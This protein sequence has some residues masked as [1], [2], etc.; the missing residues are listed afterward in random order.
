MA[1]AAPERLTSPS[2]QCP[3]LGRWY[4]VV[5]LAA[6]LMGAPALRGTFLG[7]DDIQLV[8]NHVL[9]NQPSFAHFVK[10]FAIAHRD[11][12]QPVAMV[13]FQ[14]DFVVVN[15][16]G[17]AP[18]E[19]GGVPHA[20]V[21]HAT[22]VLLHGLCA[23]LVC[24]LAARVTRS[25]TLALVAGLIFA[26]HPLNVETVAW[27]NGRMTLLSTLFLLAALLLLERYRRDGGWWRGAVAVALVALCHMS[28]VRPELPLLLAVPVL[29]AWQRPARGW[30]L[31]WG[32]V[33]LATAFF[34]VLNLQ[35]SQGMLEEGA[36][37]LHGPR[38]VR[39]VLALGW[40][41]TRIFVPLGLSPYH[42][43]P[44]AVTWHQPGLLVAALAVV[45]ALVAV[46][47]SIRW[48]RL[49]WAGALWML[50]ALGATLPLV[51]SR[52]LA[53]A[54][55]YMY[56]PLAG[57]VW[58]LAALL[59]VVARRVPRTLACTVGLVLAVAFA[60]VSWHTI[61]YYRDNVTRAA[62]MA[63]LYPGYPKVRLAYAQALLGANQL[64]R[65]DALARELTS[66]SDSSVAS[67]AWQAL[68]QIADERGDPDEALR[69]FQAAVQAAPDTA[70]A[71][72]HLGKALLA[73]NRVEEAARELA[74]AADLA[75]NYNPALLDLAQAYWQL[76]RTDDARR[77][78]TQVLG[79]NP[80]DTAALV[81]LA[82][83]DIAGGDYAAALDRLATAGRI[84]P[85]DPQVRAL[86]A[87]ARYMAGDWPGAAGQVREALALAPDQPLGRIVSVGLALAQGAPAQALAI[88]SELTK[89]RVLDDAALFDAFA[90]V[91][92]MLAQRDT[93]NPWPYY[94]MAMACH[95]TGRDEAAHMAA[96]AF[97][98]MN[99]DPQWH[100]RIDA[101]LAEGREK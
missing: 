67:E 66:A 11:L 98:Q 101:L 55:R 79:N 19:A 43:T 6:V 51:A 24:A 28:K 46:A 62:R 30:W 92:Q 60:A 90:G 56:L 34:V 54:D 42:P 12:Y 82:Q 75:P 21:F 18:Q 84:T 31:A 16:L 39:T 77:V 94:V 74:R 63:E 89:E 52:N 10:L 71:H 17:G 81:G 27:I 70:L 64:D 26:L 44:P 4:A 83:L 29:V 100:Q 76:G 25:G 57:V 72:A 87:W 88:T 20:W 86:D 78:Y 93:E 73:A 65:A 58:P 59:L 2:P 8:R 49:G 37:F 96:D 97:K 35:F 33:A 15:A 41:V 14:L 3:R 80:Y 40:Y 99:G 1:D 95:A 38:I 22:N 50:L 9:V 7:G 23:V 32:A 36:K 61:G 5:F 13:S 48:T 47:A 68:G 85:R 91:V 53:F 45:A 69:D